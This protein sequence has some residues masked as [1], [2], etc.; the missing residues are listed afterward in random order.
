MARRVGPDDPDAGLFD[1]RFQFGLQRLAVLVDLGEAARRQDGAPD[2]L[3]RAVANRLGRRTGG[4]DDHR[5]VDA[6]G[7]RVDAGIDLPAEDL[8][9]TRIDGIDRALEAVGL[10]IDQ[11]LVARLV[12]GRGRADDGDGTGGEERIERMRHG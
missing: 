12:R 4:Q 6:V 1:R 3:G 10:D 11:G 2:A 5:L 8:A 9:T 7:Q